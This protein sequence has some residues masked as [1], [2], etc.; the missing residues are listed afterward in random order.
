[1]ISASW[2]ETAEYSKKKRSAVYV[3]KRGKQKRSQLQSYLQQMNT[4][5]V[6][7][8]VWSGGDTDASWE[9][10]QTHFADV[11]TVSLFLGE[12][13]APHVSPCSL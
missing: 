6:P 9:V 13:S 2:S 1:M 7:Y 11:V 3:K 4:Q 12:M 8:T 5:P 10:C